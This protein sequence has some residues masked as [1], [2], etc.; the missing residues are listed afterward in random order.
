MILF[1]CTGCG[2][3]FSLHDESQSGSLTCPYCEQPLTNPAPAFSPSSA[4]TPSG[5]ANPLEV[6][7][8]VTSHPTLPPNVAAQ[9]LAF[10]GPPQ[11]PSELG[12]LGPYRVL[13]VLGAGGM[14]LVLQAEDPVLRRI[15]ALKVMRP[16][17]ALRETS[18]KRFLR[19]AQA[20]AA[21]EHPHIIHI[22]QVGE[23]QGVPYIAMPFLKG[24]TLD[25]R[26]QR[27]ERLS[28]GEAL[29]IGREIAEGL[30][31]AHDHGLIHRDIKPGNIWLEAR[32][33]GVKIVDF[34]LAR[35][36]AGDDVQLTKTGTILG[37][38]AY[39]AP[40][41]AASHVVDH[42]CDI[43]SLGAVL[44]QALTGRLA[45]RGPDTMAILLA[46]AT[47][48]P[49]AIE[50]VDPSI[51]TALSHLVM[52]MLSKP[53]AL[54]PE[55]ARQVAQKLRAIEKELAIA[56]AAPTVEV[57]ASP[58]RSVVKM[59]P[60]S[61]SSRVDQTHVESPAVA[62]AAA[63]VVAPRQRRW[64]LPVAAVLLLAA[65]GIAAALLL[66]PGGKGILE[67]ASDDPKVQVIVERDGEPVAII[68]P[69]SQ[70]EV[71]LRAGDYRL[72]LGD[73]GK[74][75]KADPERFT[76]AVGERKTIA[77]RRIEPM[78][79][80][81]SPEEEAGIKEAATLKAKEQVSEVAAKLTQ[82]NKGFDGNVN[83]TIE[84]GVVTGLKLNSDEV[85]DLSPIASLSGLKTLDCSGA[86]GPK[87]A[88]AKLKDLSALR[89]LPL[90]S[91]ALRNTNVSDLVPLA[92]LP[93]E[94]VICSGSKITVL[95][96]LKNLRLKKLDVSGT[97]VRDLGPLKGMAL[98]TLDCRSCP[99]DHVS[100]G[101]QNLEVLLSLKGLKN[102][103]G[104]AAE[105]HLKHAD[106]VVREWEEK[107]KTLAA[108]PVEQYVKAVPGL[109]IENQIK[110]TSE[111]LRALNKGF[112]GN[113]V[114][115]IDKGVV[116]GLQLNSDEIADIAPIRG[117]IS[118]KTLDCSGT[119]GAK[120]ATAKFKDLGPLGGTNLSTLVCRNT[121]VLD[122]SALKTVRGIE[123]VSCAGTKLPNLES[124]KGLPL[125][126]LDI[127]NT[128]VADLSP[129]CDMPLQSLSCFQTPVRSLAPLRGRDIQNLDCRQS[130]V[131][132]VA[133]YHENLGVLL[134]FKSLKNWNQQPAVDFV[135]RAALV[136]AEWNEKGA[137]TVA[138]APD[139]FLKGVPALLAE[140]QVR[141]V[142][143]RLRKLN[144]GFSGAIKPTIDKNVVVGLQLNSDDVIDISPVRA[145]AGLK[146][147][148]CSGTG[149]PKL[150]TAKFK[151]L[152]PL[153]GLQLK[154]L[155]CQQTNV[156]VLEPLRGIPLEVLVC[157]NTQV[158]SLEPLR[159]NKTLLELHCG[160]T[161]VKDLSPLLG[162]PLRTVSLV[163]TG[164]RDLAP[165]RGINLQ[166]LDCR[167][168]DIDATDV[169]NANQEVLLSIKTLQTFSA[170]P[171]A[172]YV[173]RATP[174]ANQ[175]KANADKLLAAPVDDAFIKAVG[176]FAVENQARFVAA[177]LK[178]LNPTFGGVIRPIVDKGVIT[179][180]QLNSDE[181]ADLSPLRALAGLKVLDCSGAVG[182][183]LATAKFKDLTQLRGLTLR[184]LVCRNTN[185]VD[186]AAVKAMPL[187]EL[188]CS[189]SKVPNLEQLKGLASL[190][191]LDVAGTAVPELTP[192]RGLTLQ[193][194]SCARTPVRDLAALRGMGLSALDCR[195]TPVDEL[196]MMHA[197]LDVLLS[198]KGL[199]TWNGQPAADFL[200]RAGQVLGEW[201]EKGAKLA[202][203]P[204][205][206]L[207]KVVP[208]LLA[209]NQAKVVVDR[210]KKVNA[211][212]DGKAAATID[213]NVVV[214]LRF[215]S[216]DV[217]D[218][219]PVQALAA[220]KTLDCS[221]TGGSRLAT[222]KFKDLTLLR[223]LSLRTLFVRNTNVSDLTP[224]SKMQLEELYCTGSKVAT[225]DALAG[226]PLKTLE[227]SFT[228]VTKLDP[229]RG[230]PL[231]SLSLIR[232]P[233]T[234]LSP[235]RDMNLRTLDCRQTGVDDAD[236]YHQNLD[237]LV[238]LTKLQSYN[239]QSA[240][241]FL[242]RA[243]QI[244]AEW[245]QKGAGT[246]AMSPA[247]FLKNVPTLLTENQVKAVSERLK[248]LNKG[249]DGK[250]KAILNPTAVLRIELNTD[251][252]TDLSP[253]SALA[254][255][256]DLRCTGTV[257]N[258]KLQDLSPLRGLKLA[259]LDCSDNQVRDLT[260]LTGMPLKLLYVQR[261]PVKNLGPL[262][263]GTTLET[264]SCAGTRVSD[265]EPLRGMPLQSLNI[266][267]CPVRDLAPVK[268]CPLLHVNCA[269]GHNLEDLYSL[270]DV[271]LQTLVCDFQPLRDAAILK[272]MKSLKTVNNKPVA[273]FLAAVE[274]PLK[275]V[276][277]VLARGR[278]FGE[279]AEWE[280]ADAD[281]NRAVINKANDPLVWRERARIQATQGRFDQAAAD[282]G[283]ALDLVP[284]NQGSWFADRA[285]I[286]QDLC[287]H[288][289][290]FQRVARARPKDVKLWMARTN[291]YARRGLWKEAADACAKA[292][293][294]N[295]S[296]SW[297]WFKD[298]VLRLQIGD[299]EGYR[300]DCREMM[301]RWG[302]K[303]GWF[304]T[305]QTLRICSLAPEAL[306][307]DLT[308]QKI[309]EL[310]ARAHKEKPDGLDWLV[311]GEAHSR[312]SDWATAVADLQKCLAPPVPPNLSFLPTCQAE[313]ALAQHKLA[314]SAEA[315]AAL[316]QARSLL[317]QRMPRTD[318]GA[319]LG[320]DWHDWLICR[321]HLR[322]AE[323]AIEKRK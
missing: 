175:W 251:R 228:P 316:A 132:D 79:A 54:R 181:L 80:A 262:K 12:R 188:D 66:L 46:L 94:E 107:G 277:D 205:E 139:E 154:G 62:P 230:L 196:D 291:W 43:F 58:P 115:T 300:R 314:H 8:A 141:A 178:K 237:V 127:N 292:V 321:I 214:G 261:G 153:R 131:E 45:F 234:D 208:T 308:A 96:P 227:I 50:E 85:A 238:S 24:E 23:E 216:D 134:T 159:G 235:L 323:T 225:L 93:L 74:T 232:A 7:S 246:V 303:A 211:G 165:L 11:A 81:R 265:L 26:L 282:F 164:V 63:P 250:A 109:L 200:K 16:E 71:P 35:A 32:T 75:L 252:V 310:L 309:F 53:P 259:I 231:T 289:E 72:K 318:N 143:E 21:I 14:G 163:K 287:R 272:T 220:L 197:N 199:Q 128:P 55:S 193:V 76:L 104:A 296:D 215:N 226:L 137:K 99:V 276:A 182:P 270:K 229:V 179:A 281:F 224:L 148:D 25:A 90:K 192:L 209:E 5:S 20:T 171:F 59:S 2:R 285:G 160:V 9:D 243:T 264:L 311:D 67:I 31:E 302:E 187:E 166:W 207:V 17:L 306:G 223:G 240:P 158:S 95:E 301:K 69:E 286:E 290:L 168:T 112:D 1:K 145:L 60:P 3:E 248:N 195:Q 218:A 212:Y 185:V 280:K 170:R 173:A 239:T 108:A 257:G 40:E 86:G 273:D 47:E 322:E 98:E 183:K 124:L 247:D 176:T 157:N 91:V 117:L 65:G 150:A 307:D 174:L 283:K 34:G 37:T 161:A 242:K 42:R 64:L 297:S 125:K 102:W 100:I 121:N 27:E 56:S 138:V 313:L 191:K 253:V 135:K 213:K 266:N 255:L 123:S 51:P 206:E 4:Q 190:K 319:L 44:Y 278:D 293:E 294:L 33:G 133:V 258:G 241:D 116:V 317:A 140:N 39:M 256:T 312:T 284:A 118:L 120:L 84:D 275:E 186:L 151:D 49:P 136:L 146:T 41:Q 97:A 268:T 149:G 29:R 38:P 245:N 129:L 103:N 73:G 180:V 87:Q 274:A 82:L 155:N 299:V 298:A 15:V 114:P 77:I 236:V 271:A 147:L 194:L 222:A 111:R 315:A 305:Q 167:D 156:A 130:Q 172:E 78:R 70:K 61:S 202:P 144:A 126:S 244:L 162:A 169:A 184:S 221:G 203:L 198:L 57:T 204:L 254:A 10:L 110:A 106:Q 142:S 48:T 263:G 113:V 18:R 288:E 267:S 92:G 83:S 22:Y 119:G 233:V 189:G 260:P 13:K 68:D 210:L 320:L 6:T 249:F 19:E 122:F 201:N 269:A 219:T 36:A 89:G 52:Q 28:V 304:P 279:K 177:K 105:G 295:P 88:T 30:A 217:T 101:H 152:S